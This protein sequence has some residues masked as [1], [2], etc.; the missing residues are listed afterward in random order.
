[1]KFYHPLFIFFL[2]FL[3]TV[4][5][6]EGQP[7]CEAICNERV[8]QAIQPINDEK[9]RAEQWGHEQL[10]DKEESERIRAD[11]DRQLGEMRGIAE[12]HERSANEIRGNF[13][14]VQRELEN[15]KQEIEQVRQASAAEVETL[16]TKADEAS[17]SLAQAQV[18]LD[19]ALDQIKEMEAA[20]ISVNFKGISE[21]V[22]MYW[23]NLI[24]WWTGLVMPDKKK[25]EDL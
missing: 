20:R 5:A 1:M 22:K 7:D 11:L 9:V 25:D 23:K 14:N 12:Q 13:E 8:Q 6:Q 16:R 19:Q 17:R 24:G 10:R 21:D 15:A 4:L 18:E 3:S 2:S